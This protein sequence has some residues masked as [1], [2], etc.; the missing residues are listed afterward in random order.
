[1]KRTRN[2]RN[3]T[4]RTDNQPSLKTLKNN[5]RSTN[6]HRTSQ[7]KTS[8][9]QKSTIREKVNVKTV[10]TNRTVYV[11]TDPN[12]SRRNLRSSRRRSIKRVRRPATRTGWS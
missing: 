2:I 12:L 1:M 8:R 6:Q 11:N 7:I 10:Q 4:G 9:L 3:D 5:D